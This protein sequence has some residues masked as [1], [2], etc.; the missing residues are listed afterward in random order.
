MKAKVKWIKFS[1][2]ALTYV[3]WVIWVGNLWLMPGILI[4]IDIYITKKVPWNFWKK[5]KDG[6]KPKAWVEWIDALVFALVA[7]YFIN[8]F[9]FQNYKIP[10]SSM[11]NSLLVKDHLFVSKVSFGPRIPITPLS[12]PLLQN[13][14]PVLNTKSYLEWP[15]WNYRRLKG[16]GHVKN[17]D[18]VVF[19]FPT[20]DTVPV[21]FVNPDFY[22]TCREIGWAYA[23]SNKSLLSGLGNTSQWELNEKLKSIGRKQILL[24]SE[25]YG[26]VVYR[27]VDRRDNY[28]KRCIAIA[29]DTLQ[30]RH[31]QVYVNGVK[32]EN[33]EGLQHLYTIITDGTKFNKRF[34][35]KLEISTEDADPSCMG[36]G[37][38]YQLPLTKAKA[39]KMKQYPFIRQ[40]QM[41]EQIV[42]S[43][44]QPN[45]W[46]YSKDYMWSRDNFGPLYIPKKG[47]KLQL[48]MMNLVLYDRII[49]AY[50][51]NKLEVKNNNIYI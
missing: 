31:N 12:F 15:H 42:D 45:I 16:F 24:N 18:I 29:G 4:V 17:N 41:N 25:T 28:V 38:L 2:T 9:L 40:I 8:L 14:V 47:D 10:S 7:V 46:P 23:N 44:Q 43:T 22:N 37:P 1:F 13:T 50:E 26:E 30:I 21:K 33:M 3:L 49:T 39:E 51:G 48:T 27:P 19:N 36:V 5:T 32:A 35:D 6:S 11:E 20:G 34:L